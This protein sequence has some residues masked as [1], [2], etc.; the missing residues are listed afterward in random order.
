MRNSSKTAE[1]RFQIV[2]ANPQKEEPEQTN[3]KGRESLRQGAN[4]SVQTRGFD[5][6]LNLN[7][8]FVRPSLLT[9]EHDEESLRKGA[10]QLGRQENFRTR[11]KTS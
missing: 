8:K 3:R 9:R 5:K 10:K 11:S 6:D 4:R 7:G 1:K 2:L